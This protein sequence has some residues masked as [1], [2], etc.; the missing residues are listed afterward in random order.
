MKNNIILEC[1]DVGISFGGIKAVDGFT[2]SMEK[3]ELLGLIGPN[4]AGKTTVFNMLSGVYTPTQGQI[5]LDGK[6]VN[7]LSPDKLSKEGIARTFQNIRL[8][9]NLTVLDNVKLA[10]NQFMEYGVLTGMF[11]LPKYWKE[12][13]EATDKA[14]EILKIF[15]LEKFFRAYA[16]SLPYGA[17]RKLEI[18]RAMATGPKVLLLDEPAAGM[19]DTETYELMNS[20]KTVRDMLN[21]GVL[22]IEHDMNLVLGICERLIVLNYGQILAEGDPHEVIKNEEV[23]KA[24][25]GS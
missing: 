16:G 21:I 20:I 13:K 24:Y 8:F 10:M 4:G 2:M 11:R 6:V 18:A 14:I 25:L 15:E 5:I 17:Q 22:L 9:E 19:N 1:K 12:E 23:V 3:G 7:R